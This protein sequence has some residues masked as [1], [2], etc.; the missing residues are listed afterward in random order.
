MSKVIVV[1]SGPS[2]ILAS[3]I[4]SKDNE[5]TIIERNDKIGKK[6]LITGNGKCNFWN[7]EID[8][9][10]YN[11]DN[12]EFL[13]NILSY[14]NKVYK[15][16]TEEL[17]IYPY[18]KNGY[19]YPNSNLSSSIIETF[20][21][22]LKNK[23]I[24]ILYNLK[25]TD[26]TPNANDVT[27]TLSD[28]TKI[29]ADKVIIATG[30]KAAPKTGSDGSGYQLLDKLNIKINPVKPALVPLVSNE[31]FLKEW[32]NIRT[33]VKLSILD[34]SKTIKEEKGEIQLTDYGISGIV[35]FNISSTLQSL[36]DNNKEV[37]IFIDFL[38]N[39]NNLLDIL[40]KRSKGMNNPTIE[41]LLE[42]MLNYKLM[43]VI[44]NVAKI[45]KNT[46]WNDLDNKNILIDTIKNFKINI[47]GTEDFEKAQVC[48][49]GIS[50]NELDHSFKLK[51]YKNISVVGELLDVDGI[52]GGYNLAFA[53]I[54]GYI[55]GENIND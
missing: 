37:K 9:S 55:A 11:T 49:G 31:K 48:R 32:A 30:S 44:L 46:K 45:D 40:N 25:V 13:E 10:K 15:Y 47:I 26:I 21:R 54:T 51:K 18:N 35:T 22:E 28:N 41:A 8:I 20:K 38:P 1:G 7:E 5:V 50:L 43:N 34:N 39:E 16:L 6:I 36:L 33:N 4:A 3:L 17:G 52:C 24:N 42:T 14:K 12:F 27:L 23:N 29:I 53:F 2:G 19:I